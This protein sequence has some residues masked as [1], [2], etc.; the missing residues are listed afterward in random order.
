MVEGFSPAYWED[1]YAGHPGHEGAHQAEPNAT[2]VAVAQ[3]LPPGSALD[4][5]CGH[6]ADALWLA[7]QGWRVTAVDV[8]G[9]VIEQARR[10]AV[11]ADADPTGRIQW[12]PADLMSWQPAANGYD[13][14]SAHY[15]HVPAGQQ[16]AFLRRLALAVAPGGTLLVVGHH[17]ADRG[18]AVARARRRR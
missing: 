16:E 11:S 14:V 1:R 10:A 6:G 15:V 12:V 18:P 7:A 13:L 8:A 5:G 2:L 9:T 3:Q 4:A 17:P